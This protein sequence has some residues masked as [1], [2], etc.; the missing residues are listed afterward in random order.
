M[1]LWW[2]FKFQV[3]IVQALSGHSQ[4]IRMSKMWFPSN[5]KRNPAQERERERDGERERERGGSGTALM[6]ILESGPPPSPPYHPLSSSMQE[7]ERGG[8][9]IQWKPSNSIEYLSARERERDKFQHKS[10][11]ER[12]DEVEVDDVE[13]DED[14][15]GEIETNETEVDDVESGEGEINE[16][17]E[18]LGSVLLLP[19]GW[20]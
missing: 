3:Y 13:F 16:V 10:V 9:E 19:A 5:P 14:D 18:P 4:F 1:L 6:P 7:R 20:S 17:D 15:A 2:W 11:Q 12:A 8:G